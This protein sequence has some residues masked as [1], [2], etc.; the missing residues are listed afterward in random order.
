MTQHL[1]LGG[2][3][4]GKSSYAEQCA[5]NL[6]STPVYIATATAEDKEMRARIARH[7][8][9]RAKVWRL[10]EE[11][12]DLASAINNIND[13]S[14]VLVDCLSLWLSNCLHADIWQQHKTEFLKQISSTQHDLILVSNEVGMG[15]V[16]MGELS[17]QF[18][19]QAGWLHQALAEHCDAVT[20]IIAG[21]PQKLK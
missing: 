6:S 21:L 11:P 9:D 3:R 4:S 16:P 5:L 17:R 1:I 18:V 14:V 19:D 7:Q 13:K 20:L 15:V 2:A 12:L 10:I 8:S